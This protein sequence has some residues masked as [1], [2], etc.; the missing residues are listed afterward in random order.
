MRAN[1]LHLT[2]TST[3]DSYDDEHKEQHGDAPKTE[4]DETALLRKAE[5]LHEPSTRYGLLGFCGASEA[6]TRVQAVSV[7]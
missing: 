4:N 7:A 6:T 3:R 2:A 1:P 5:P